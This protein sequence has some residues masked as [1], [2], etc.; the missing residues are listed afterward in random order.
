[1]ELMILGCAVGIG[2][3]SIKILKIGLVSD[4]IS[5]LDC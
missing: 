5:A 2:I 4:D 3:F 1:M